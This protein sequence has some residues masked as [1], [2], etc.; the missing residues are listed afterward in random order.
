L[1]YNEKY[2]LVTSKVIKDFKIV[3][4]LN[5]PGIVKA[6][7]LYLDQVEE[8]AYYVMEKVNGRNLKKF[9]K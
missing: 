6:H 5:H 2:D 7:E 9:L 3:K 8:K 4:H 1:F